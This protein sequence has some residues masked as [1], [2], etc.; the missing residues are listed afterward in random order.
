MA[1]QTAT[2]T[3][4]APLEPNAPPPSNEATFNKT[5]E[6]P[7][8]ESADSL[9][10]AAEKI[11][12]DRAI[13]A[14]AEADRMAA[15][16][17]LLE[18]KEDAPAS[19]AERNEKRS[20]SQPKA[21]DKASEETPS[22]SDV[23]PPDIKNDKKEDKR[24]ETPADPF[25]EFRKELLAQ[26]Q[27]FDAERE[28]FAKDMEEL[29]EFRDLGKRGK[30]EFSKV[31]DKLGLTPED[32]AAQ[33]ANGGELS[34]AERRA[35]EAVQRVEALEKQLKA[36]ETESA[37]QQRQQA[38]QAFVR[39]LNTQLESS[40]KHELSKA[41]GDSAVQQ[42]KSV[43]EA[44][45]RNT[46]DPRT[47]RGEELAFDKAADIVENHLEKQLDLLS[48]KA[49]KFKSKYGAAQTDKP[50][51][52]AKKAS[53]KTLSSALTGASK[54][55]ELTAEQRMNRALEMLRSK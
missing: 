23:T 55:Q 34:P 8:P 17:K 9:V 22:P 31:L 15:A 2:P 54:P 12:A 5:A 42:I 29:K 10:V 32:V 28:K 1:E 45:W 38:E 47:G 53:D 52:P 18:T 49:G 48:S 3:P 44:H 21:A 41:L 37:N 50:P 33:A 4:A 16:L 51:A 43:M 20:V 26:K 46:V 30:Y 11:A 19:V 13:P 35:M 40:S 25:A 27:A 24:P 39:H 36:R 7:M 14:N 6:V